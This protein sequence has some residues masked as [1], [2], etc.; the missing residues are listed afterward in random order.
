MKIEMG[1]IPI[2]ISLDQPQVGD[3]Y[4]AK[5][6]RGSTKFFV[7]AAVIGNM[8]HALGIDSEG[9]IVSTTSYGTHVFAGRDIVGRVEELAELTLN[10]Q[11]E[12]L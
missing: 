4:R 6:G 2:R 12:A 3:V 1:R 8:A 11:W 7:V 5:G 10:I 9:Q